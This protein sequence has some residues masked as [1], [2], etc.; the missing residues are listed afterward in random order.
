MGHRPY[1]DPVFA[2]KEQKV[3]ALDDLDALSLLHSLLQIIILVLGLSATQDNGDTILGLTI[4]FYALSFVASA[5]CWLC[6]RAKAKKEGR[7]LKDVAVLGDD[8]SGKQEIGRES[9]ADASTSAA[10]T[11]AAHADSPSEQTA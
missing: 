1:I 8:H 6:V 9:N 10:A 4:F 2:A 7:R 11:A 3:S 5:A